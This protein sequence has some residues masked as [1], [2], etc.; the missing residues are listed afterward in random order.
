MIITFA[1]QSKLLWITDDSFLWLLRGFVGLVTKWSFF[2]V[3][4]LEKVVSTAADRSQVPHALN[5]AFYLKLVIGTERDGIGL[6]VTP[7][8]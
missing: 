6:L 4:F 7:F 8:N 1:W 3:C 5:S 2:S